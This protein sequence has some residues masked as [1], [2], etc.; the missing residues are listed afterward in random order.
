MFEQ[1]GGLP[2][3]VWGDA[4]DE[5]SHLSRLREKLKDVDGFLAELGIENYLK[6]P[7]HY[8]YMKLQED[9][10][11]NPLRRTKTETSTDVTRTRLCS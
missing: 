2:R 10:A 7:H 9:S 8:F 11:G 5:N 4:S 1:Y 3:L 6:G